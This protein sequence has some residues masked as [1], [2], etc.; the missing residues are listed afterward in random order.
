MDLFVFFN[1]TK[2]KILWLTLPI[3]LLACKIENESVFNY[4]LVQV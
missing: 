2:R 4:N 3:G 1:G